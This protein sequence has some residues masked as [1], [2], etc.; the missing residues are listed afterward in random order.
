MTLENIFGGC[1]SLCN[2]ILKKEK[3]YIC[4]YIIIYITLNMEYLL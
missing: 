4:T 3:N 1:L 2:N